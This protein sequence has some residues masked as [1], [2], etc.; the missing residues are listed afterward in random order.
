M[1]FPFGYGLSYTA[2]EYSDFGLTE[3]MGSFMGVTVTVTNTGSVAGKE[4][5]QIRH[6]QSP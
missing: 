3:T 1:A 4:T 6:F 5:V 2:F